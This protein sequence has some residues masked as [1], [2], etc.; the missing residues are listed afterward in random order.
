MSGRGGVAILAAFMLLAVLASAALATSRN[1]AREL[2][3]AGAALQGAARV[4]HAAIFSNGWFIKRA[5]AG[6][7]AEGGCGPTRISRCIGDQDHRTPSSI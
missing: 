4:R 3:M 7:V 5:S 2:A 1:L 6:S